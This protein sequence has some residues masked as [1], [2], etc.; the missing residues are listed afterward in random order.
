ME[1]FYLDILG[2]LPRDAL[3]DLEIYDNFTAINGAPGVA[4]I[5]KMNRNTSAGNPWKKG[6]RHFMRAVKAQHG[7]QN[8]VEVDAEIM[9]RVDDIIASY[10]K[11]ERVFPNFCA[12]LKDEAVSF[13]KVKAKKTRVFTGAPFDWSIVVRKY[14]LSCVRLIQNNRFAFEAAPGTVAQS[15]E[16]HELRDYITKFG[17]DRI[18]AGDY[19]AF[20]KRM[21][22]VFIQAAFTILER[23]CIE[24][25][26]YSTKDVRVLRGIAAD[27]AFPLVDF[28]GDM[29]EFYGTNPSGHPLTVIINSLVNSL[30]MRYVYTLLHPQQNVRDFRDHVSL[31]T[32]GDDNI[33]SVSK[34]AGWYNH[35]AISRAFASF[36]ITYTMADKDAESVPFIHID[37]ASFLKRK[38]R[39]DNDVGVY[40]APLEHDSIEKMLMVWVKSKT[41]SEQEQSMAVISSAIREYFYYGKDIFNVKRDMLRKVVSEVNMDHWVTPDVFPTWEE[42]VQCFWDNTMRVCDSP[43]LSN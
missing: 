27:T 35:T 9:N 41:I 11:Q 31:M 8:P 38:W 42:L 13:K 34:K 10:H 37:D 7:M 25:G 33:L 24:S 19:K 29:V 40:L 14:Y 18:V 20:D 39:F 36:D 32:Y 12:H 21:S 3:Q 26:N 4:Y 2:S 16:W 1:S 22:P 6:K 28:N 17:E 15:Y 23:L 30:Y 5:D 43:P